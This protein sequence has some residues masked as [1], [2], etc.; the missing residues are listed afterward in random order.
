MPSVPEVSIDDIVVSLAVVTVAIARASLSSSTTTGSAIKLV[1]KRN[2]SSACRL[3]G[4]DTATNRR[5]PRLCIGSAR[6][7]VISLMS[8][9]SLLICVVSNAF[10]SNSGTP[11]VVDANLA[12]SDDVIRF[13]AIN[14]S[15]KVIEAAFA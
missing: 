13:E 4:S 8:I 5:L 2:S 9:H 11:N 10:K 7:A 12:N 1:L 15:T 14:C 6:R 3:V